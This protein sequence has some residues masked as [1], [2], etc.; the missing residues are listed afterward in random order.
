MGFT[1]RK[2]GS[3]GRNR[4]RNDRDEE[5]N[6]W[7]FKVAIRNMLKYLKENINTLYFFGL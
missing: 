6:I 2:K 4:S 3:T 1:P 7:D 5:M